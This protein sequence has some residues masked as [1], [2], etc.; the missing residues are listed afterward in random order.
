MEFDLLSQ[1]LINSYQRDFPLCDR[2]FL[3][4]A[5]QFGVSEQQ[6][7]T[8]LKTLKKNG[9]LS[10]LGPV[11]NHQQAGS[12][13]LAAVAVPANDIDRVAEI[14]NNFEQI[15]HNYA[16]EHHYNLWF[17]VTAPT[18]EDLTQALTDIGDATACEVL[19]LPMEK[20][21]HIDLS[22]TVCFKPVMEQV[23]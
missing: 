12:S 11:F 23:S 1:Q 15:N 22:F 10:R 5:Q 6:V 14:I 4:L 17:V 13:T 20:S 9:V 18:P 3:K 19:I 16:R 8:T 2:P 7:L 21:H